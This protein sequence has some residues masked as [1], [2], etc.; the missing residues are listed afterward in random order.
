M[1]VNIAVP[2]YIDTLRNVAFRQNLTEGREVYHVHPLKT[3]Q[4]GQ[5]ID[6]YDLYLGP[7][8]ST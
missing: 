7:F 5:L 8:A 6:Y 4:L 2:F 1:T 3:F